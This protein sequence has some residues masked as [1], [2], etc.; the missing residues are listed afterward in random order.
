MEEKINNSSVMKLEEL[1]FRWM[2]L[3]LKA[4]TQLTK[5][6][7]LLEGSL[8]KFIK[9][10]TAIEEPNYSKNLNFILWKQRKEY[11]TEK[12]DR[13]EMDIS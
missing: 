6:S 12:M 7:L 1:H 13:A 11:F 4:V 8:F 9:V 2:V 3:V 10:L 5:M